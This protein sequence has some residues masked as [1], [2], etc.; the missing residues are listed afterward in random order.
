MKMLRPLVVMTG[1]VLLT[2]CSA[3]FDDVRAQM[4][5]IRQKPRGDVAPAP[6]FVP[7]PTFT[8]AAHQLR[9]PF[10]PPISADSL[11]LSSGKKVEPDLNRAA[12]YLERF[13]LEALRFRGTINRPGGIVFALIEDGDGGIQ[14]VKVGNHLGKNHGK[15]A[16][17]SAAQIGIIEI[18]PDGRDGWV[19]RPRSLT[20]S[21]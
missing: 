7:M 10:A 4:D 11:L 20:L 21:E 6:E 1:V 19:E 2:G 5:A 12:E 8:Y 3:S 16:E 9:S 13:N 15:I 18:V 14:R 17:I